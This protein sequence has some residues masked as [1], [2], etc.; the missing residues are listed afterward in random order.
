MVSGEVPEQAVV[1]NPDRIW[2]DAV[3]FVEKRV[4]AG[5]V[6]PL[7]TP[8]GDGDVGPAIRDP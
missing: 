7:G 3:G 6:V 1:R 4:E 2:T 8:R 5:S